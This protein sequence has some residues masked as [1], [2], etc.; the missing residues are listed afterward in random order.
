MRR[1]QRRRAKRALIEIVAERQ[2]VAQQRA[3]ETE[4]PAVV[5]RDDD[6]RAGSARESHEIEPEERQ[7][8]EMDHVRG[9]LAQKPP[10][11]ALRR[12]IEKVQF[13]TQVHARPR[14]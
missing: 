11:R 2:I 13:L 4:R 9:K 7:V 1:R 12:G 8:V 10:E 14:H 5:Q 6:L 3:L